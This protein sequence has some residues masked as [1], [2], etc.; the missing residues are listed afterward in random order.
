MANIIIQKEG[1]KTF[2]KTEEYR[3]SDHND[4]ATS[5]ELK[6]REFTGLRLNSIT[7]RRE[8]WIVGELRGAMCNTYATQFPEKWDLWY[9]Q[10]FEMD[11]D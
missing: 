11:K 2:G 7:N 3:R 1:E 5:K 9:R 10:M 8:V 6:D 4:F